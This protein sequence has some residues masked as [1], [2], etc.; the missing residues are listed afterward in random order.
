[1]LPYSLYSIVQVLDIYHNVY[2]DIIA[3]S[4]ILNIARKL[5]YIHRQSI[6]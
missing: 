4:I 2:C 1:M 5:F 3:N 6:N